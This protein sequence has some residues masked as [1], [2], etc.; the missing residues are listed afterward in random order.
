M[1]SYRS[2]ERALPYDRQIFH[3]ACTLLIIVNHFVI[4]APN[5][6]GDDLLS[7]VPFLHGYPRRLRQHFERCVQIFPHQMSRG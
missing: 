4:G 1:A 2:C 6:M 3:Y 7:N 5:G